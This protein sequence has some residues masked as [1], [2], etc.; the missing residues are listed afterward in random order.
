MTKK[1]YVE[2]FSVSFI[3]LLTSLGITRTHQ[4]VSLLE[5]NDPD[6]WEGY[7]ALIRRLESDLKKYAVL[8]P[9]LKSLSK[10]GNL[11]YSDTYTPENILKN[12]NQLTIHIVDSNGDYIDQGVRCSVNPERKKQ[13]EREQEL[14]AEGVCDENQI[15]ECVCTG[16]TNE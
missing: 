3:D 11:P 8:L 10:L 16:G 9:Q 1:E 6:A 14:I 12:D 7:N 2:G 13:L 15:A 5:A 4:L